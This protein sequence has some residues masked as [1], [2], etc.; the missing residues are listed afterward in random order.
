MKK[1]LYSFM[2]ITGYIINLATF[3]FADL[4]SIVT[5]PNFKTF[6]MPLILSFIGAL[7]FLV[8]AYIIDK[9]ISSEMNKINQK[10]S[11]FIKESQAILNNIREFNNTKYIL[12]EIQEAINDHAKHISNLEMYSTNPNVKKEHPLKA[13]LDP[14]HEAKKIDLIELKNEP[15]RDNK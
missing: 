15:N 7:L 8:L 12:R 5:N 1:K 13:K 14:K 9:Y 3:F 11:E 6:G 10:Q 2:A 4:Q